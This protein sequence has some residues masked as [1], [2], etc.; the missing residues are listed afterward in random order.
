VRA[1]GQELE[2]RFGVETAFID[3]ENPV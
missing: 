2:E 3:V 1:L